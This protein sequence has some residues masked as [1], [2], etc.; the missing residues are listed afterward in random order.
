MGMSTNVI[1]FKPPGEKWQRMKAVWDACMAA[2]VDIP[3]E[4]ARYFEHDV[5]DSA[6]VKIDRA[7]LVNT[8]ALAAWGTEHGQEGYEVDVAKLPKDVTVIRFYNSW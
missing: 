5:P 2:G 4:V 7:V 8:G 1:A 6:G 3:D